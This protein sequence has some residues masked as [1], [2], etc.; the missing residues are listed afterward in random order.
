VTVTRVLLL[1]GVFVL[2]AGVVAFGR[3][4]APQ[5]SDEVARLEARLDD[6][7]TSL[8]EERRARRELARA[9]EAMAG[10]L[11]VPVPAE[12]PPPAPARRRIE[13]PDSPRARAAGLSTRA[14]ERRI[15]PQT[16]EAAGFSRTEIDAYVAH[17][18]DLALRRL[19][20]RD[21]ATREGWVETPRFREESRALHDEREQTRERF[22]DE[23][24]DWALFSSG[25]P[26]RVQVESVIGGS[27]A[28][29]AGIEVGDIVQRY[30]DA[31]VLAYADLRAAT[32]SGRE[33]ESTPIDILRAGQE[34]RLYLPRGPLGVELRP[35]SV[36]PEAVR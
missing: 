33:G 34:R 14:T 8:E 16:L 32:A 31:S 18:D 3:R 30:A 35:V 13:V 21:R 24:H 22:G 29:G 36:K 11:D 26:N 15:D 7:A 6:V 20:L 10:R 9:V 12:P 1:A 23:L 4:S 19:Q 5:P 27:A 17:V 2:A 25:R 28:A